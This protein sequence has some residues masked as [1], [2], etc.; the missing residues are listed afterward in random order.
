M[1]GRGLGVAPVTEMMLGLSPSA[2][3]MRVHLQQEIIRQVVL[4]RPA[5]ATTRPTIRAMT[6][7]IRAG[8]NTATGA[9]VVRRT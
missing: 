2:A 1:A 7:I 5:G 6:E 8:F 4:I 9:A 3:I